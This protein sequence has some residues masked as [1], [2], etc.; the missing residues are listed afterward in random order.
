MFHRQ[1]L[2]GLLLLLSQS[3]QQPI[4]AVGDSNWHQQQHPGDG[5]LQLLQLRS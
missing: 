5:N 2:L 3:Q 1:G 4:V